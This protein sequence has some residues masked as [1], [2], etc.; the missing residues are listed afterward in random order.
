MG[1][2]LSHEAAMI[3]VFIHTSRGRLPVRVADGTNE[4]MMHFEIARKRKLRLWG[5]TISVWRPLAV[6]WAVS[7]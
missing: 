4:K 5:L 1:K 7:I 3:S 6:G 2:T